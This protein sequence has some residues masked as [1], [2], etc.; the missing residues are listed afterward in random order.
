M[1]STFFIHTEN[2]KTADEAFQLAR[3]YDRLADRKFVFVMFDPIEGKT[4]RDAAFEYMWDK[5]IDESCKPAGC[6]KTDEGFT[7]FGWSRDD[8][9]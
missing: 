4:A 2:T 3:Q 5:R 6:F 9:E 7:F 1:S 8:N